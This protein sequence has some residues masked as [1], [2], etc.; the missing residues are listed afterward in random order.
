[1]NYNGYELAAIAAGIS[2]LLFA[3]AKSFDIVSVSMEML[4]QRR[5]D[6]QL[7]REK[8]AA[9]LA[10]EQKDHAEA[11]AAKRQSEAV[12]LDINRQREAVEL[13]IKIDWAKHAREMEVRQASYAHELD[14]KNMEREH[15]PST[16]SGSEHIVGG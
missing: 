3:L 15:A 16:E 7:R 8:E 5:I 9:W 11:L 4:K 6:E 14:L 12:E 10:R 1:M 13:D 2:L